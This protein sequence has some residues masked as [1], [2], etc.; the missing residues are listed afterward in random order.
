ME[1]A[2]YR[3]WTAMG[4]LTTRDLTTS[5]WWNPFTIERIR[6]RTPLSP[7]ECVQRIQANT[8][9]Y[10][11]WRWLG[12]D[13]EKRPFSGTAKRDQ[14]ALI[15]NTLQF[16]NSF[17][18]NAK[19][20]ILPDATSADG[21]IINIRLSLHV[22]VRIWL[23]FPITIVSAMMLL[24]LAGATGIIWFGPDQY[25]PLGFFAMAILAGSMTYLFYLLAFWFSR[26]ERV[27][28]VETL[29]R[30]LQASDV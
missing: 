24:S 1:N 21:S 18:P 10:A 30:I 25:I 12:D 5:I 27:F 4:E 9:S 16:R 17:R 19:C 7:D 28:L 13:P 20:V 23:L 6:L 26:G 3:A 29:Q 14:F 15:K 11:S 8:Y 22:F 2:F